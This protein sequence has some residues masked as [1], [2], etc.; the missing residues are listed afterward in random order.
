MESEED[1]ATRLYEVVADDEALRSDLT[2]DGFGPIL[3]WAA[4]KA[5]SLAEYG[6]EAD[7]ESLANALRAAVI[8]MVSAAETN[9]PSE[10]TGIDPRVASPAAVA[11]ITA[12][13]VS[14]AD[15]PDTRAQA[16]AEAP[17]DGLHT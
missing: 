2:D 8:S 10:L 11:A 13:L 1:L 6:H 17:T 3:N 14:A 9:N 15:G 7:F 4:D 5:S 12:A 16:M